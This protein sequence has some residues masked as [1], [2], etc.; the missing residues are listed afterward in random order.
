MAAVM[1]MA[2]SRPVVEDPGVVL[3]LAHN[4]ES[5]SAEN[6]NWTTLDMHG[7]AL[8]NI[9]PSVFQ[10]KFL[11]GLNISKNQLSSIPRE[12]SCL[13]NLRDLDISGN[14]LTSLPAELGFIVSLRELNAVN[15]YIATLP[16]ELGNL[17]QLQKFQLEGNPL[18]PE[19]RLAYSQGAAGLV[20]FLCENAPSK[21]AGFLLRFELTSYCSASS[22]TSSQMGTTRP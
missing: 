16:F 20:R 6:Q 1:S 9:S 10:Y 18:E 2:Y 19:I 7:N 17:Y 15:N 8:R 13:T 4:S 12:I 14:K 3:S 11:T 5:K 21:L 22:A